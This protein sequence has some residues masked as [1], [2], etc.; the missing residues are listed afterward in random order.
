MKNKILK[1]EIIG[2]G[3]NSNKVKEYKNSLFELTKV[4]WEAAIGLMLGDASLQSQNG[5]KTYRIKFEWGDRN[6]A[7]ALHVH[8]LFDEWVLSEPHKKSRVSPKGK[9]VINWGFQTIS[10]DAFK[11]LADL[12]LKEKQK[13]ISENLINNHLTPRG[14]AY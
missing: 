10:H 2:L 1:N 13:G 5:G 4:Q 11:P 14:L 9:L 12:F 8:Q 6:K 7:Y 3:P